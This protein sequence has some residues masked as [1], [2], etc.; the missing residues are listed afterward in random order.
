[1]KKN[2]QMPAVGI[3]SVKSAREIVAYLGGDPSIIGDD[4]CYPEL[5]KAYPELKEAYFELIEQ[6][7]HD[8]VA[9]AAYW[10]CIYLGMPKERV[11]SVIEKANTKDVRAMA[12]WAEKKLGMPKERALKAGNRS[13]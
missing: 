7:T 1:M 6:A 10:A 2:Q 3:E 8:Y 13:D 11:F 12:Y 5:E 4:W 9:S